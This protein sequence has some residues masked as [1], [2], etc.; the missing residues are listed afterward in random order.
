M[1]TQE[2]ILRWGTYCD[3]DECEKAYQLGE[4][5]ISWIDYTYKWCNKLPQAVDN[6]WDMDAYYSDFNI[7]W[8]SLSDSKREAI[9]NAI[10]NK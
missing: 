1:A 10:N 5:S 8:T 7:W 3:L 4:M 2:E 9:Y 6:E